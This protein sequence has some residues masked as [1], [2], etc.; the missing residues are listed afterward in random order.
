[1]EMQRGAEG[2]FGCS[3][4]FGNAS[5]L[6]LQTQAMKRRRPL[7]LSV[8]RQRGEKEFGHAAGERSTSV[9]VVAVIL[10]GNVNRLYKERFRE[11]FFP[12][13]LF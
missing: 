5:V 8:P 2:E 4:F 3:V 6:G 11:K 12:K 10:L 1:M 7:V 9:S 13:S